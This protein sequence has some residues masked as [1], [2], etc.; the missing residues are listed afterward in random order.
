MNMN[1]MTT[2]LP[3]SMYPYNASIIIITICLHCRTSALD[4]GLITI[5]IIWEWEVLDL[6]EDEAY[7]YGYG[8]RYWILHLKEDRRHSVTQRYK[9]WCQN[10][11]ESDSSLIHLILRPSMI[12]Q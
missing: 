2:I 7:A 1:I 9:D 11:A 5:T 12:S 4:I 8:L 6:D 10:E 3:K